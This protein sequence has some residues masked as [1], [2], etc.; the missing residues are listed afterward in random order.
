MAITLTAEQ[1][2]AIRSDAE[3]LGYKRAEDYLAVRLSNMH[4]TAR[5]SFETKEEFEHMVKAGIESAERG[6]LYTPDEVKTRLEA[7]KRRF[8]AKRTAA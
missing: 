2:A 5:F 8:L 3:E 1:E 7:A 6:E 4:A